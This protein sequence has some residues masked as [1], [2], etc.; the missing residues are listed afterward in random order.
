MAEKLEERLQTLD[1]L[2]NYNSKV[3]KA[4]SMGIIIDVTSA[5]FDEERSHYIKRLKIIDSTKPTFLVLG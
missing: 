3:S 1:E 5:Y 4:C 2:F